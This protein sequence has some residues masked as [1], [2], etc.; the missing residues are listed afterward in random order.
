MA[1]ADGG[2]RS[3]ELRIKS[4]DGR[5]N[6]AES[7]AAFGAIEAENLAAVFLNDS[8]ADAEAEAGALADRLGCVE[9]VEDAFGFAKAGARVR[10]IEDDAA[11]FS[12][13]AD[14]E[15]TSADGFHGVDGIVDQIEED[16]EEL[17]GVAT[18]GGE[19]AGIF[20]FDADFF[21]A[22]VE[23]AE[24]DGAGDDGA[25]VE[26]LF[27][28][29]DLARE[30]EQVGD[31]DFGAAGLVADFFAKAAGAFGCAGIGLDQIGVAE[32]RGEGI[33]DFVRG[34]CGKLAERGEF[35]SLD[36]LHLEA[37]EIVDGVLQA[38]EQSEALAVD[39]LLAQENETGADDNDAEREE[40]AEMPDRLRGIA[41]EAR[42]CGHERHGKHAQDGEAREPLRVPHFR[43]LRQIGLG[44]QAVS[45][46]AD[47]AEPNECGHER[48]IQQA[49][50][51]IVALRVGGGC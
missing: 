28:G 34:A 25:Q 7:A 42:P 18:H 50:R 17:V 43:A 36:K 23:L 22:Q 5:K 49:A 13:H 39:E 10:K 47:S 45:E 46:Y 24:L 32:D 48:E 12:A 20:D 33:I 41:D 37:L 1:G 29:G 6:H 11:A 3:G 15:R 27:F 31:E 4:E 38:F 35:F 26:K 2:G 8:V 9:G 21:V 14:G 19:S 51:G 40:Q 30:A 16:L 44:R